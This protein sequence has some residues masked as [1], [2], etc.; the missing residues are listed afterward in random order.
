M[1]R[2]PLNI[3]TFKPGLER[4]IDQDQVLRLTFLDITSQRVDKKVFHIFCRFSC[5]INAVL[6]H[7]FKTTVH[8]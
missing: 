5:A 8:R 4:S 1:V 2:P 3:K 7:Q 6:I